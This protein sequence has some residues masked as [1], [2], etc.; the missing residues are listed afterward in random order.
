MNKLILSCYRQ[1]NKLTPASFKA[2][3]TRG[4]TYVAAVFSPPSVS[5]LSKGTLVSNTLHVTQPL[6]VIFLFQG[7]I[8]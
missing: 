7:D 2:R 4:L 3:D 8:L 6:R 5:T 1:W